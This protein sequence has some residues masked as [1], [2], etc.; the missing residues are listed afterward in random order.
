MADLSKSSGYVPLA[1]FLDM[2]KRY[3]EY[4]KAHPTAK[5]K[6]IYIDS[7]RIDYVNA[8]TF[9]NM[10]YRYDRYKASNG[11]QMPSIVYFLPADKRVTSPEQDVEEVKRVVGAIQAR[12]EAVLGQFNSFTEFYN[13]SKG[14]GY[15]YYYDD[16]Y[17]LEQEITRFINKQGLNC[18]DAAQLFGALA[19][20]MGY[21]WRYVHV[22]CQSGGHIRAQIKG[23]E[24]SDWTRVDPAACISVGSQ[25]PIS[26][27]WCDNN[28]A[29][30]TTASW[31]L[32]DDG[33]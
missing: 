5:A 27:V 16:V 1:V 32:I 19:K 17:T 13:K 4:N 22:Q 30:V 21:S 9:E 2:N 6:I 20:E 33:A 29:Y 10:Q 7:K 28:T 14:R 26:R 11:G 25:Y 8:A 24:F 3:I 31:I 18:S 23:K 12:M 15:K